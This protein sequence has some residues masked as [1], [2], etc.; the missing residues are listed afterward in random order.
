[1]KKTLLILIICICLTSCSNDVI[2]EPIVPNKN[3]KFEKTALFLFDSDILTYNQFKKKN[4]VKKFKKKNIPFLMTLEKEKDIETIMSYSNS[5]MNNDIVFDSHWNPVHIENLNWKE[6][7]FNHDSWVLY[8]QSLNFIPYLVLSYEETGDEKYLQKAEYYILSWI[9]NNSVQDE[10]RNRFTWNDHAVANR[11]KN[12]IHFLRAYRDSPIF[13]IDTFDKIAYSLYYHGLFM[14]NEKNY[15]PSNHGLMQD[16][17]LLELST[18]FP[19]FPDSQEWYNIS[20]NRLKKSVER[21][22]SSEGI[23]KEHSPSYHVY[24]QDI[25]KMTNKFLTSIEVNEPFLEET[26]RIMDEYGKYIV[27]PSG[28]YPQISDTPKTKNPKSD[29][30]P[31]LKDRVF[32]KSGVG[33]FLDSDSN[34]NN[35]IYLMFTAAYNSNIHK[36][37]DDLAFILNVDETDYFIDAGFMNYNKGIERD[38]MISAWAHNT[39]ILDNLP[40]NMTEDNFQNPKIEKFQTTNSVSYIRASHSM[41]KD[42]TIIRTLIYIKPNVFII[43]DQIKAA[44]DSHTSSQQ[45]FNIGENVEINYITK[46]SYKLNS[47]IDDSFVFFE[48]FSKSEPSRE[49]VTGQDSPFLGWQSYYLDEIHPINSL[50]I[51]R[52]IDD[53]N[54]YSVISINKINPI[55]N[56]TYEEALDK[57]SFI[58]N[59][60]KLEVKI[61][62]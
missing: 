46:N 21:D 62:K 1:M 61:E 14:A 31:K 20:I 28:D 7:P 40:W 52:P 2:D 30:Y 43:H 26:I 6:N 11:T 51:N 50:I 23:H 4:Q 8:Y 58:V 16:Q 45:I 15:V 10:I 18:L 34:L 60:E 49:L 29:K 33:F 3:M 13:S 19:F 48:Q 39:I 25:Y 9:D 59:G 5:L 57:Y 42:T 27:T 56:L 36:H 32:S 12:I 38:Y 35:Q 55:S 17:A 24:V 22:I 37:Q 41:Y 53:N 44:T 47:K 54:I